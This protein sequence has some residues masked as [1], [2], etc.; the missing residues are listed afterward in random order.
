MNTHDIIFGLPGDHLETVIN[1][2]VSAAKEDPF[3]SWLLLP[4]Q[5]LVVT[6]NEHFDGEYYPLHTFPNLY[7]RWIL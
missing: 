5:R 7:T 2:F 3:T 6:C 4:T 1:S